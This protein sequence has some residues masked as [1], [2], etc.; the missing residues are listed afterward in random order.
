MKL[1]SRERMDQLLKLR[2]TL[3]VKYEQLIDTA[4]SEDDEGI[5][6]LRGPLCRISRMKR[7]VETHIT[8]RSVDPVS[9]K[10][11]DLSIETEELTRLLTDMMGR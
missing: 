3:E 2:N 5:D 1:V 9:Q 10:K 8:L 11:R 6:R 7:S 4:C